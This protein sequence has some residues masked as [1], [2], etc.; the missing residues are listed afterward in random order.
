M[1]IALLKL[2]WLLLIPAGVWFAFGHFDRTSD[3]GLKKLGSADTLK[4]VI[5]GP[6]TKRNAR[7]LF[8][9]GLVFIVLALLR[10]QWGIK[11]EPFMQKGLDLVIAIDTSSSMYTPDIYPSR[12]EKTIMEVNR[13]LDTLQGD[14]VSLV[15]FAGSATT[16]TPLTTDYEA[17]KLFMTTIVGS[18]ENTAGTNLHAAVAKCLETFDP[19]VPQDKVIM[20]FTDGEDHEGGLNG[21]KDDASEIGAVIMPVC[22]GTEGGQPIPLLDE[23]G[24]VH[25]Y[26]KDKKGS[27]VVSRIHPENLQP[28]ATSK[29]YLLNQN[30]EPLS[31]IIQELQYYKRVGIKNTVS[32]MYSERFQVFL[33]IGILMLCI[34]FIL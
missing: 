34:S 20:I 31:E 33:F 27:V 14:R 24:T 26:K 29:V 28:L 2:W 4:K 25:G 23:N 32:T 16:I 6:G 18:R 5:R 9:G 7:L 21:L 12:L 8:V 15:T 10:P 3:I 11:Q 30:S 17:L 19:K 22:V 1:N 13:L